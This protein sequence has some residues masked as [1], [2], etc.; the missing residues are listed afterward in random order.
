[1]KLV[2]I[3][4][5]AA[6]IVIGGLYQFSNS[7]K[8]ESSIADT[9]AVDTSI[10][11]IEPI[12]EDQITENETQIESI[13]EDEAIE[14]I[15][16]EPVVHATEVAV[17]T[18]EIPAKKMIAA[19]PKLK[20]KI[21][22]KIIVKKVSMP[23]SKVAIAN[24]VPAAMGKAQKKV[25]DTVS[26]KQSAISKSMTKLERDEAKAYAK[27][28]SGSIGMSA[29]TNLETENSADKDTSGSVSL[30]LS[31]R[32]FDGYSTS[33]SIR[34][35]KGLNSQNGYEDNVG[36][37]RLNLR[38][39]SFK[40]LK[41]KI[42]VSPAL[43]AILP[44]SKTSKLRDEMIA[45][46]E[47]K[48][49]FS[50]NA[51]NRLSFSYTPGVR[52]LFHNFKNNRLE[53]A[54]TQLYLLQYSSAT[55]Q[56]TDKFYLNAALYY[57]KKWSHQGQPFNDSYMTGLE[58]GYYVNRSTSVAFG[59]STGGSVYSPEKGQEQKIEILDSRKTS[60]YGSVSVTF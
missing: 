14:H 47:V 41:N 58:A 54:N 24:A 39:K 28:F 33:A 21:K 60:L 53:S 55:Y 19:S 44:T 8:K 31:Y 27:K 20:K 43:T 5:T 7:E 48:S 11:D 4:S 36:D 25:E 10:S 50:Y 59:T 40:I 42:R 2:L 34:V 32:A 16:D 45:G 18:K 51:T 12:E 29:S 23:S 52:R 15:V 30:A 9:D 37:L 35:G 13:Q 1:M 17:H 46:L 38:K 56:F 6:V 57:F 22:K 49:T 3:L 26:T